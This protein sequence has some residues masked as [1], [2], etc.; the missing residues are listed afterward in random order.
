MRAETIGECGSP[1][2]GNGCS[3]EMCNALC[4][5]RDFY[6]PEPPQFAKC[7][8]SIDMQSQTNRARDLLRLNR[9]LPP[10]V[11]GGCSGDRHDRGIN[12]ALAAAYSF[13][14]V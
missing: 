11:L 14:N 8:Q 6:N 4:A 5:N 10:E 7:Y 13:E 9:N 12:K 3:T 2:E 1:I